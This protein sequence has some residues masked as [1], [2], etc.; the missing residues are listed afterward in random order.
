MAPTSARPVL[1]P[2]AVSPVPPVAARRAGAGTEDVLETGP[3]AAERPN[4]G[5]R[6]PRWVYA[7]LLARF[8]W[9][10]LRIQVA[11]LKSVVI[12]NT[13]IVRAGICAYLL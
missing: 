6:R 13:I 4:F 7:V 1:A 2:T 12:C 11:K 9:T 5:G 3:A 8:Y 10:E